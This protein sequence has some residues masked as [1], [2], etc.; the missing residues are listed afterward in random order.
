MAKLVAERQDIVPILAEVFREYGYEGASL[1]RIETRCGLGKGSLYHFF[2]GGKKEMA[3][4]VL[5]DIASWFDSHIFRPLQDDTPAEEALHTMFANVTDYFRSGGR[6]CLMGAF[7]LDSTRDDFANSI[8]CFFRHWQEALTHTL[9]CAD[10]AAHQAT[11]LANETL[12]LIQGAIVLAR[13][14]ND[15]T[16]FFQLLQRHEHKLL[17]AG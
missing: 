10:Y 3:E 9:I 5:T 11:Q 6:V 16:V 14:T 7:A 4:A 17:H 13:A 8:N 12:A 1:K 2:P 15:E